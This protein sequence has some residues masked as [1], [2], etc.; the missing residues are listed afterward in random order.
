MNVTQK[1]D[2]CRIIQEFGSQVLGDFGF[3]NISNFFIKILEAIS[4]KFSIIVEVI[5]SKNSTHNVSTEQ[6]SCQTLA[7][8]DCWSNSWKIQRSAAF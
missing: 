1:I 2:D 6:S 5:C 7:Q 3:V 4:H 8:Y